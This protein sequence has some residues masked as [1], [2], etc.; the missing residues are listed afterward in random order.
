VSAVVAVA[1]IASLALLATWLLGWPILGSWLAITRVTDG[2]GW[3][4]A[5]FTPG[6][7][8]LPAWI[9]LMASLA[10]F[11]PGDPHLGQ[12]LACHCDVS[13]PGWLHLC[14]VHPMSASPLLVFLALPAALL[15]FR[16]V[17]T[18][19]RLHAGQ[20]A[21]SGSRG[22]RADDGTIRLLEL[23]LPVVFTTGLLWPS[24]S[25][26]RRYWS[27]LD[28][29]SRRVIAAHE[30]AHVIRRDPLTYAWLLVWSAFAPRALVTPLVRDWLAHAELRA[31]R[32]AAQA[33][34]DAVLVAEVLVQQ[35]RVQAPTDAPAMAWSASHLERR[36]RALL[37]EPWRARTTRGD[38]DIRWALVAATVVGL[39]A[40]A[41]PWLH[42]NLEH[43][44]NTL[45]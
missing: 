37:H 29:P 38:L 13:H 9:G 12:V 10:A 27:A 41:S 36:V 45:L 15:L 44:I 30:Q 5:R 16:P 21:F 1:V 43:L 39:A 40:L 18:A 32:H 25:A 7:V 34:G 23:G 33:V 3:A 6:V 14:P 4:W 31:D 28:D 24:V 22:E 26:D 8:I 2:R 20:R 42:H 11:V 19:L 35:R 17:L